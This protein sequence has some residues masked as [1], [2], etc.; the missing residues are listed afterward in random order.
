MSM[1]ENSRPRAAAREQALF[2]NWLACTLIRLFWGCR[3]TDLGPFRAIR[4]DALQ[5][6]AMSDPTFRWTVEMQVKAAKL[7]LKSTEVPVS[8]RKRIGTSKV[9]GTVR[10]TVNA[11]VKILYTIF[12]WCSASGQCRGVR[13]LPGTDLF[14][15]EI[16]ARKIFP[17]FFLFRPSFTCRASLVSYLACGIA[18][19]QVVCLGVSFARAFQSEQSRGVLASADR[20]MGDQNM[21]AGA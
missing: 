12:K 10:G 7:K 2:G 13:L 14:Y 3:F 8:Y 19:A 9:T 6:M 18:G 4:V 20:G 5:R 11:S 15:E 16:G 17:D 21:V 1:S